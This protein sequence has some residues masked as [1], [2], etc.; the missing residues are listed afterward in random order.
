MNQDELNLPQF[1]QKI[2]LTL[3]RLSP[4]MRPYRH[5]IH[6]PEMTLNTNKLISIIN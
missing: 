6:P 3:P 2:S 1:P 4:P 5:D